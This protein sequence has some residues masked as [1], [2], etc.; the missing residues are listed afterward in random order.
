MAVQ[1]SQHN[2]QKIETPEV[3]LSLS[4][5]PSNLIKSC[6]KC[7]KKE[8]EQKQY[9]SLQLVEHTSRHQGSELN[10]SFD[11]IA[12]P[13]DGNAP[14]RIQLATKML[15]PL[16]ATIILFKGNSS[17]NKKFEYQVLPS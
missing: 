3:V 9:P 7:V 6:R 16:S 13:T 14:Q 8:Q 15:K 11:R 2:S 4:E 17:K 10:N 5:S 1:P 12:H